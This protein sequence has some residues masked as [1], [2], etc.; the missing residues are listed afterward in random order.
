M[1]K[2]RSDK[3]V[4]DDALVAAMYS[5]GA[6]QVDLVQRFR[7][8]AKSIRASLRR[9]GLVGPTNRVSVPI[10]DV[11]RWHL[12]EDLSV[13][14]ISRMLGVSRPSVM[15]AMAMAGIPSRGRSEADRV[16]MAHEG[17]EGRKRLTA[18]AHDAVRG[19]PKTAEELASQAIGRSAKKR[20]SFLESVFVDAFANAGVDVEPQYPVDR[21]N[22]D[23]AIPAKML[24]VEIDP[25]N[26]HKTPKKLAIDV[27]RDALLSGLGWTVVRLSGP[28][29]R[30]RNPA[31]REL[32]DELVG[33]VVAEHLRPTG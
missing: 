15:T 22:I 27:P 1:R 10:D 9:T 16:R 13:L 4:L 6:T 30:T 18:A 7:T 28:S 17:V 33:N 20:L 14:T 5:G 11:R 19:V 23:I 3:V 12:D 24:A 31:I 2:V 29:I 25:G 26:W 8:G 32:A 21:Y